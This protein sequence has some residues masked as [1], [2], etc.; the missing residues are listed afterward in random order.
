MFMEKLVT[1]IIEEEMVG[2]R[3]E[4]KVICVLI[5]LGIHVVGMYL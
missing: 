5:F 1:L 4:N 3:E 2:S